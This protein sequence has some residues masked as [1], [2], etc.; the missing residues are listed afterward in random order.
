VVETAKLKAKVGLAREQLGSA[1][2]KLEMALA[3]LEKVPRA[4]KTLVGQALAD[5]FGGLR[6]P[7]RDLIELEELLEELDAK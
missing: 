2:G 3:A 5:A 7:K 6:E 4:Q 1:E